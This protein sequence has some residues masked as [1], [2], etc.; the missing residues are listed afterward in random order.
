MSGRID[1]VE[2]SRLLVGPSDGGIAHGWNMFGWIGIE[3]GRSE[4]PGKSG[5]MLDHRDQ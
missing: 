1:E 2:C 5:I 3:E 4:K